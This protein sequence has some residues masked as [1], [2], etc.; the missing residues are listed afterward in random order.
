MIQKSLPPV[1]YEKTLNAI[2]QMAVPSITDWCS[3]DLLDDNGD[4]QQVVVAHKDLKKIAWAKSLRLKLGPPYL[5]ELIGLANVLRTGEPE[6]YSKIT[7][8]MLIEAIK[9]KDELELAHGLGLSSVMIVPL[10]VNTKTIGVISF[11]SIESGVHY[12]TSDLELAKGIA[13][14]AALAVENANLYAAA[15]RELKERQR[16][17]KQLVA[18]NKALEDRVQK[19]TKQLEITNKGL[20]KEIVKRKE[21]ENELKE[22][23]HSLTQSNQELQDFAYVASH[24]LQEP[25]RKIQAFGDLLETEFGRELGEGTEYVSRMRNAASRMSILIEDLLD[26]SRVSTKR[27]TNVK[28]DLNEIVRDVVSDLEARITS[29]NGVVDVQTLPT[30][31][32][33]PTHMR[34]LFQNLISNALKFHRAGVAPIVKVY[35]EVSK[36]SDDTYRVFIEDNG[37]GFDEKYLDRIF[38]VFQRLHGKDAYEGTGIGLAVCRKIVER[39][40]GTIAATSRKDIGSTF[41]LDLPKRD[42]ESSDDRS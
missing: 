7:D 21:V 11:L 10:I 23:S 12:T 14:R 19:R 17:Q 35:S 33:D 41:I 6:V 28:V 1:N 27:Q 5:K 31:W 29:T 22:H 8:K 13:D 42:K 34:Q 26:F 25:L 40:S 15:R 32:A 24:D 3:V 38:S 18:A 30:V 4:L 2:A 20:E 37:I 9:N 39:Y 36:P 16:L